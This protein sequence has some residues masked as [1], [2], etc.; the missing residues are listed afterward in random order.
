M[1][2]QVPQYPGDPIYSL[3][4]AFQKDPREEKVSLSIGTYCDEDG[5]IPYMKAVQSAERIISDNF[6]ARPYLPME[7][8]ERFRSATQNLLFGKTHEAVISNRI[9]TVQTVGATGALRLGADFLKQHL[10]CE[11]VRVS[12][13]TWETHQ[14]IF[15]AAGFNVLRYP[16]YDRV[17]GGVDFAALLDAVN[18]M[19]AGSVLVLHACAH[20]PTGADLSNDQWLV[21]IDSMLRKGVIP[22][23]DLAYQGFSK[24]VVEDLFA[25][26][27]LLDANASFLVANSYSKNFALYGERVGAL[28]VVCQTATE[29]DAVLGQLKSG[30][31]KSYSSPP[32]HGARSVVEV[33]E[34][35]DLFLLWREELN[36]MRDRIALMR[37]ELH[38]SLA[39]QVTS[40]E[41]DYLLTQSGMFSF[42]GLNERQI[43]ELRDRFGVYL[44]G[45]GRICIAGL[46]MKKVGYVAEAMANV[47]KRV[48]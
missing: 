42:T 35:Q 43:R 28:S 46:T 14:D 39:K 16:Y 32:T 8:M 24:G 5:K 3:F 34:R 20:N 47:M 22:F 48:I 11:Q 21:L 30:V 6:G 41:V 7:G 31:R 17:T 44:V 45:N 15:T 27:A 33:L 23:L 13:F 25:V 12:D 26:R 29:S 2:S 18:N 4:E 9:A 36:T 40:G 38:S 1:F 37:S 19:Q 10:G